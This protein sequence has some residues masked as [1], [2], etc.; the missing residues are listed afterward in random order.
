[1]NEA[2]PL[3][4]H[5]SAQNPGVSVRVGPRSRATV[6]NLVGDDA[7]ARSLHVHLTV[8]PAV[9]LDTLDADAI[10]RGED[11]LLARALLE[12]GSGGHQSAIEVDFGRGIALTV[13]GS[14]LRVTGLNL[15]PSPV[16]LGAFVA[17]GDARAAAPT[18]TQLGPLLPERVEW[19]LDVPA[20]ASAVEVLALDQALRVE[21]GLGRAGDRWRYGEQ[22]A[23]SARMPRPLPIANGC[24]RVRVKNLGPGTA[25]PV[26]IFSLA[27]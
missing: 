10:A 25:A 27:L 26:A 14:A 17:Y 13:S 4:E 24:A 22:V 16:H 3:L 1:M 8:A 7:M 23:R 15:G 5:R 6:L 2:R 11:E 21:V 12:L 18:L 9:P 19:T 20:Y